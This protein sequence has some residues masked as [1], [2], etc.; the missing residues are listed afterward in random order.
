M[1]KYKL[2]CATA[3]KKDKQMITIYKNSTTKQCAMQIVQA[4]KRV[5]K[6]NLDVMHTVIVPD[7]STLEME[8]LILQEIGGSFNVQVLTFR[9]LASRILPKYEYLSK[10]A[11]IMALAGIIQD[12]KR[13][14][15]C[16]TKGVDS[17]GF[18]AD[19]YDTISMMK[20]CKIQPSKLIND[21]LPTSVRGKAEDIATLY[22]AYLDY[23]QNRFVD[24]ADKLDLLCDQLPNVQSVN[25]ELDI[26]EEGFGT[27]EGVEVWVFA[28]LAVVGAAFT[29][30]GGRIFRSS[31][32]REVELELVGEE[33]ISH[34]RA[35]VDSGNLATEPISG[36]AVIFA[37]AES[38]REALG[39][40]MCTSLSTFSTDSVCTSVM[41]KIRLVPSKSVTGE[42][43]LPA[44]RFKDVRLK[45][46]REV[47][48][49]DVYIAF[50][51]AGSFGEYDAIISDEAIV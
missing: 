7:R 29:A 42:G 1:V 31:A 30:R 50:V 24:S 19:M 25:N 45:K 37:S 16:F 9:R 33:G 3:H 44:L 11:G 10:Q 15:K 14:L 38:C 8:R 41:S 47:K 2:T 17:P 27:D 26:L 20:Y 34:L 35:L 49:L 18:V 39:E 40:E 28:F 6:S 12:N 4:L 23:T 36:R 13:N 22:R 5:D 46:G 21:K 32:K 43:L 48:Y 51:G